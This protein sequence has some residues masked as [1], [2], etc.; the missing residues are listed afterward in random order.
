MAAGAGVAAATIGMTGV[1]NAHADDGS[2]LT[3]IS[4]LDAA[5]ADLTQAKD[6]LSGADVPA[7]FQVGTS[8]EDTG[9][10]F[11]E[12][13]AEAAQAPLLSH[14]DPFSGFVN[15]LFSGLDQQLEHGAAAVLSADQ[16]LAADP[17][18]STFSDVDTAQEQFVNASTALVIPD[19]IA[20]LVDQLFGLG[21]SDAASSIGS[22]L[23]SNTGSDLATSFS[24]D[25]PF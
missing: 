1:P 14:D 24:S 3:D 22:D 21:G 12:D 23:A 10:Q 25:L 6:V 8:F 2:T 16:A 5:T 11:V 20:H 18:Q 4:L 9:L 19:D 13:K 17:S 7:Q 15:L